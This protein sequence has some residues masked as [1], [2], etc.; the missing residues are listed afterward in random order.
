[1]LSSYA[2]TVKSRSSSTASIFKTRSPLNLS[3]TQDI[4]VRAAILAQ[5]DEKAASGEARPPSRGWEE[6]VDWGRPGCAWMDRLTIGPQVGNLPH[7]RQL[8]A[9]A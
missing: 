8:G 7:K 1:M 9:C 3:I 4:E 5:D 2:F 6:H